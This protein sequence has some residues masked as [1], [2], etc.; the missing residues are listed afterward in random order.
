MIMPDQWKPVSSFLG[1][2]HADAG[3]VIGEIHG[4]TIVSVPESCHRLEEIGK[5]KRPRP[6]V[7]CRVRLMSEMHAAP[8]L[9]PKSRGGA[10][11]PDLGSGAHYG[12]SPKRPLDG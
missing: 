12:G 6:R 10:L 2:I 8:F 9:A 3:S 1:N 7:L 4:P 5:S 11:H